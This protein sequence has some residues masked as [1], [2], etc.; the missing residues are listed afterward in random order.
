MKHTLV[1]RSNKEDNCWTYALEDNNGDTCGFARA[2]LFLGEDGKEHFVLISGYGIM[3]SKEA[4]I[5]VVHNRDIADDR[6][7]ESARSFAGVQEIVDLTER[8]KAGNLEK[9]TQTR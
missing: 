8:G 6:I 3:N 4:V 9:A 1:S 5:G 7:Y 2:E